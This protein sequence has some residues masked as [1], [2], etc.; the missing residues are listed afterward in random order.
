M[1][2]KM[3][4][5]S[6]RFTA[7]PTRR[8]NRSRSR[9]NCDQD[10]GNSGKAFLGT[11]GRERAAEELDLDVSISGVAQGGG[12]PVDALP[13]TLDATL[14]KAIGKHSQGR[15]QSPRRHPR[16]VDELD[17]LRRAHAVQLLGKM[18]CLPTN[19]LD[20]DCLRVWVHVITIILGNDILRH[21]RPPPLGYAEK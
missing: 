1:S 7:L 14:G 16:S 11:H 18:L 9:S 8:C 20:S 6:K 4:F 13:P 2:R 21:G 5:A 3:P 12:Q 17:I 19:I 15:S 10:P